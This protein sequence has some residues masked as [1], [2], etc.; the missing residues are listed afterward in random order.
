MKVRL[1]SY[2]V[3]G[4]SAD[5][6]LAYLYA[7][8]RPLKGETGRVDWW[9]EGRISHLIISGW[10]RGEFNEQLLSN[11]GGRIKA[12][13]VLL[14][15]LGPPERFTAERY[16]ALTNFLGSVIARLGLHSLVTPLP[17][18]H[19]AQWSLPEIPPSLAAELLIESVARAFIPIRDYP[20]E[21]E[22][23]ITTEVEKRD[24]IFLG[25]QQVKVSLK[26]KIDLEIK[27]E[28]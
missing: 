7:G 11:P 13:R 10:I 21:P 4:Y 19:Q 25:A 5:I 12:D 28:E 6:L 27:V 16:R 17:G 22:M 8:E 20:R 3:D 1:V 23:L 9:L 2:P 14:T 24:E 18:F 15:G 26:G